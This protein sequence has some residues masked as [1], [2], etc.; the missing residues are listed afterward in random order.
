VTVAIWWLATST[1]LVLE[2]S[3]EVSIEERLIMGIKPDKSDYIALILAA[4]QTIAI[5]FILILIILLVIY[6]YTVL[7]WK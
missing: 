7:F 3:I 2:I 4:F 1:E 6:L 5:P